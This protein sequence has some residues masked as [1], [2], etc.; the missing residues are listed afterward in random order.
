MDKKIKSGKD[1]I[2]EF[3]SEIYNIENVDEKTVQVLVTL[4]SEDNLTDKSIQNALDELLQQEL[5][6]Q[7][8]ENEKA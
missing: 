3:F 5:T 8:K 1:V 4:Y 6:P 2:D 7:K